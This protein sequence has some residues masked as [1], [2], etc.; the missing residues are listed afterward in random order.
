MTRQGNVSFVSTKAKVWLD[1]LGVT[2]AGLVK[3]FRARTA[4][5]PGKS[6]YLEKHSRRILLTEADS[7]R[8][9]SVCLILEEIP[10]PLRSLTPRQRETLY[11]LSRGKSN[12]QIADLMRIKV[13]T[14]RKHLEK[15]FEELGVENRAAAAWFGHS[16]SFA[17]DNSA[18]GSI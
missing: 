14:V 16:F 13:S 9:G 7:N 12:D 10:G 15:T 18:A 5:Q 11:W 6:F 8:K 3:S 1:D 17:L 2:P 4:N